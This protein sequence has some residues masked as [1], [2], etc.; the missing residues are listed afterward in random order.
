MR[1]RREDYCKYGSVVEE[2]GEK[3]NDN[4]D[5]RRCTRCIVTKFSLFEPFEDEDEQDS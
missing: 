2:D 3:I 1:C 4:K 5:P